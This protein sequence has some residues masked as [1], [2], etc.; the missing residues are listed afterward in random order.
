MP[1]SARAMRNWL[2]L[3]FAVAA[4]AACWHWQPFLGLSPDDLRGAAGTVAQIAST[5]LGFMIAALAILATI[6]NTVLVR[7]MQKTGHFLF[8]LRRMYLAAIAYAVTMLVALVGV[9][10]SSIPVWA[11]LA[12]VFLVALSTAL[13]VEFGY[14]FWMVLSH[15]R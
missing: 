2:S 14:R 6:T 15:L 13:L 5:M 10:A 4:T 9:I 12:V 11:V 1:S 3:A 8:L 7:N